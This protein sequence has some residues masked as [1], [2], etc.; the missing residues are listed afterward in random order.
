[1]DVGAP[2]NSSELWM[3]TTHMALVIQFIVG[4]LELVKAD[5]LS[6]PSLSRGRRV[7]MNVHP[8]WHRGVSVSSHHPLRAVVNIPE[9]QWQGSVCGLLLS[10]NFQLS[11]IRQSFKS[12]ILWCA[13]YIQ[14]IYNKILTT[15]QKLSEA[16]VGLL[17]AKWH[18]EGLV[19]TYIP[20]PP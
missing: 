4:E 10:W 7:W 12:K 18:V 1:M 6:H 2:S 17:T 19:K 20:S 15:F 11:R 5:H 13:L 14:C 16:A 9:R 3:P 8:G